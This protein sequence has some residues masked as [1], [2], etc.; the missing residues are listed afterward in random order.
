MKAES[1]LTISYNYRIQHYRK[2]YYAKS[3]YFDQT[4]KPITL[5]LI[6]ANEAHKMATKPTT[7]TIRIVSP[8]NIIIKDI[9]RVE[10]Q[11]KEQAA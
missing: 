4:T 7:D 11:F 10:Y 1:L 8:S 5:V 9:P 2:I 6:D 3:Y